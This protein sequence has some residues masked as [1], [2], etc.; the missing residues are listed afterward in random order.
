MDHKFSLNRSCHTTV[1]FCVIFHSQTDQSSCGSA[2]NSCLCMCAQSRCYLFPP[3]FFSFFCELCFGNPLDTWKK[4][5]CDL[6]DCRLILGT[7]QCGK[8]LLMLKP[9]LW[10][11]PIRISNKRNVL[12]KTPH[13]DRLLSGQP[14]SFFNH[15]RLQEIVSVGHFVY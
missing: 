3:W 14:W 6:C 10:V 5:C 15:W 2:L 8:T 1:G 12:Q 11:G 7:E 4:M 9:S 13:G